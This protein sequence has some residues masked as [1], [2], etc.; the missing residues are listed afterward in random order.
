MT[1]RSADI[2]GVTTFLIGDFHSRANIIALVI[3]VTFLAAIFIVG[4]KINSY[5]ACEQDIIYRPAYMRFDASHDAWKDEFKS[6]ISAAWP[7]SQKCRKNDHANGTIIYYAIAFNLSNKLESDEF[8]PVD[9]FHRDIYVIDYG[10][11]Q[12]L[13]PEKAAEDDVV[14]IAKVLG[15]SQVLCSGCTNL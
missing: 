4:I 5:L 10:S 15:C 7:D 6:F 8:L 12:C 3:K 14:P 2:P 11:V 13:A 9:P 1:L